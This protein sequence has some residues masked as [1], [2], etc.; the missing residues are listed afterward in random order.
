MTEQT[1]NQ[2]IKNLSSQLGYTPTAPAI[3]QP[4]TA[5]FDLL[6]DALRR[7]LYVVQSSMNASAGQDYVLRPEFTICIAQDFIQSLECNNPIYSRLS[8]SGSVFR[9]ND[10]HECTELTQSGIEIF[11]ADD[12]LKA[13]IEVVEYALKVM[14]DLSIT[15]MQL[16]MGDSELISTLLQNLDISEIWR[17]KLKR[18][19]IT[20]NNLDDLLT[21]LN[22]PQIAPINQERV[23]FLN[24][25]EGLETE[26][27]QMLVENVL[28]FSGIDLIGGRSAGEIAERFLEQAALSAT[29]ELPQSVIKIISEFFAIQ[30]SAKN[31]I[32][33]L[34]ALNKK[35]ALK[36][37]DNIANLAKRFSAIEALNISGY[38]QDSIYFNNLHGRGFEYYTGMVFEI[39]DTKN[40]TDKPLI[41]GGRYDVLATQLGAK[42]PINAVGASMWDAHLALL[43]APNAGDE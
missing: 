32:T 40:R 42:T 8:Y 18:M 31:S 3:V 36:L 34:K 26:A 2:K 21:Q 7:R 5:Y 9:S 38:T 12:R 29:P 30:G 37:D 11:A 35:Y 28:S 16:Q 27:A 1:V 4:A 15:D 19:F 13:D 33:Q 25:I 41:G 22:K 10:Q 20:Q 23:A 17:N 39:V 43:I 14:D 6:G 24:A